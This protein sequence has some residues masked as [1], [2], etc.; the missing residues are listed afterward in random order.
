MS[1]LLAPCLQNGQRVGD[2]L[3]ELIVGEIAAVKLVIDLAVLDK[4]DASGAAGRADGVRAIRIVC[5]LRLMSENTRSSSSVALESSAPVGSSASRRRGF[6]MIARATA[7]RC[8]W[9]PEISYGY[10]FSSSVMPSLA[11]MGSS[12]ADRYCPRPRTCRAD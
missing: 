7:A 2:L 9:P 3:V 12:R 8:F 1:C 10:F 5:P 4:E 6:V 11:A